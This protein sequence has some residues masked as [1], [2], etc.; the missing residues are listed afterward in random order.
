LLGAEESVRA[1]VYGAGIQVE[2]RDLCP[3]DGCLIGSQMQEEIGGGLWFSA[4]N[5]RSADEDREEALHEINCKGFGAISPR[6]A[7]RRTSEKE[8][9]HDPAPRNDS[10]TSV[11]PKRRGV[12]GSCNR[13]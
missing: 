4:W 11:C 7:P 9:H 2:A 12:P 3:S 13:R 8:K 6:V 1:V 5:Q 10:V